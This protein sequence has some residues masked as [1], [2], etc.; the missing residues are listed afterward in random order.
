MKS[1]ARKFAVSINVEHCK[2]CGICMALC[3]KGILRARHD[4]RVEVVD[5]SACIG[6]NSCSVHCPDFCFEIKERINKEEEAQD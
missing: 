1:L 4:G 3:P 2:A 5:E 6:C